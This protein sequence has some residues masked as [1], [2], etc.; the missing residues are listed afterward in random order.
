MT[1]SWDFWQARFEPPTQSELPKLLFNNFRSTVNI[2]YQSL[3]LRRLVGN[4]R[5]RICRNIYIY[6][7]SRRSTCFRHHTSLISLRFPAY[8]VVLNFKVSSLQSM[9]LVFILN[10][11]HGE[12]NEYPQEQVEVGIVTKHHPTTNNASSILMALSAETRRRGQ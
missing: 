11:F 8:W 5:E 1:G 2:K 10:K 3:H 9:V 12:C 6:P 7:S 4:K